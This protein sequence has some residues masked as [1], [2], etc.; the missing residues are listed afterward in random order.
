MQ[1]HKPTR[2]EA[3]LLARSV[4]SEPRSC[5][6]SGSRAAISR[7]SRHWF[8]GSFAFSNSVFSFWTS[9]ANCSA[10]ASATFARTLAAAATSFA[11]SRCSLN[12]SMT[13]WTM[14]GSSGGGGR[15]RHYRDGPD[16]QSKGDDKS[17]DHW[18]F[19]NNG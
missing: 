3:L 10:L 18:R 2:R 15:L 19:L 11:C 14:T 13:S 17:L 4:L 16:N 6:S 7:S 8:F 1:G 5:S 12:S 9:S